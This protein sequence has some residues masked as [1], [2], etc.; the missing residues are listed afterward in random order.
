FTHQEIG[1]IFGVNKKTI[2]R[3]KYSN[4][5]ALKKP[6][7]ATIGTQTDLTMEQITEMEQSIIKYQE[8]ITQEQNKV[9]QKETELA[10]LEKEIQDLQAQVKDKELNE[11]QKELLGEDYLNIRS[12]LIELCKALIKKQELQTQITT[13]TQKRDELQTKYDMEVRTKNELVKDL[14][15]YRQCSFVS[16]DNTFLEK[17]ENVDF[18][19]KLIEKHN[20]DVNIVVYTYFYTSDTKKTFAFDLRKLLSDRTRISF[21]II[22]SEENILP[23]L[24][25]VEERKD[26]GA[27]E[28]LEKYYPDKEKTYRIDINQQLAGVLDCGDYEGAIKETKIIPCIPAQDYL[29]QNYPKNGTCIRKNEEYGDKNFGKTREEIIEL[30]IQE[31]ALERE[32]DLS[33]FKNLEKLEC[34]DNYLTQIIYPPN[35]E[36]ITFLHI[37]NNN[38]NPSNL[39]IFSQF[40]NLEQLYIVALKTLSNSQNLNKDFLSELTLYKMFRSSVSN[41]VPCYGI[42]KDTEGNYIMVMKYMTEGN[43]RE[44]LKKNRELGLERKLEFLKQIIQGLKDIHRIIAYEILTGIP[45]FATQA[46]DTGLALQ[47]CRGERPQFPAQI[48]YPQI[49]SAREIDEIVGEWF[50][51]NS[52]YLKIDTEFYHQLQETKD[53]NKTLPDEIKY[54]T[55]QS[56]E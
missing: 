45:P 17:E 51:E 10:N 24:E 4:K 43:L 7:T 14:N 16:V 41:M 3:W 22:N 47:I 38:I 25:K 18:L 29:N 39:T 35:P 53:Y 31:K 11:A 56:Q 28:W 20:K 8:Q 27:G 19:S 42:S 52:R 2:Q 32:L 23:K 46:H 34:S 36:K 6:P 15:F 21:N 30:D 44:Y 50:E 55:Y 54:P 9:Q 40:R 26:G 12:K 49:P 13:L 5:Q 33:D 37:S 48:K 1:G